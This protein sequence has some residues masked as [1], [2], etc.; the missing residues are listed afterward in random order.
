MRKIRFFALIMAL[1]MMLSLCACGGDVGDAAEV[2]GG[3]VSATDVSATDIAVDWYSAL[4]DEERVLADAVLSSTDA[5][6]AEDEDA[7]MA[8]IDPQ[9]EAFDET[10]EYV[11]LVF[12]KY[13]L[14]A[15]VEYIEIVEIKGDTAELR[16]TQTTVRNGEG[17][18]FA[19]AR[20]VLLHTMVCR[21]GVWYI[22]STI[23]ESRTE[24]D[25][26]WDTAADYLAE[27][28]ASSSDAA[29]Q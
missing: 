21:D 4:S 9:S 17:K 5:F 19:D 26:N 24:L 7:Y 1:V 28:T 2:S 18:A 22:S 29:A 11:R 13:S 8:T 16:V 15:T 12:S 23:V 6:N 3:D 25:T 14:T 27:N 20:T 10:L